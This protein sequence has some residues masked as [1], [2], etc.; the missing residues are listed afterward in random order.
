MKLFERKPG[1]PVTINKENITERCLEFY[2]TNGIDNNSFNEVIKYAGVSKGSIYRIYGSEDVLQKSVLS[3]YFETVVNKRIKVH[4][5]DSIKKYVMAITSSLITNKSK[6]CL[7][8]RTKTE[9]YKL[10]PV[11]RKFIGKME[12]DVKK[13]YIKMI[14]KDFKLNNKKI[15]EA[16]VI[17]TADYLINSMSTLTLIKL[18]TNSHKSLSNFS[19]YLVKQFSKL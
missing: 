17:E 15:N 14:K 7:F 19:K 6:P 18:N 9:K 4:S 5:K 11:T 13:S 12:G 3:K 10:G 2:W 8:Y 1:R 16:D